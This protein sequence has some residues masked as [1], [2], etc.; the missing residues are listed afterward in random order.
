MK[1]HYASQQTIS[2]HA[3]ISEDRF[4]KEIYHELRTEA[5]LHKDFFF[6]F[7]K[8]T[9]DAPSVLDADQNPDCLCKSHF[10]SPTH[11][12]FQEDTYIVV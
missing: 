12:I 11:S 3:L 10:L 4:V 1:G 2:E 8:Y 6:S 5:V 7:E 9:Q